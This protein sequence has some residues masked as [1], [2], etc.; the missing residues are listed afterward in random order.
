M[1]KGAS[2]ATG[3]GRLRVGEGGTHR[4]VAP[5][6]HGKARRQEHH[7]DR[8]CKP[9]W[10]A[11]VGE[12]PIGCSA[13]N[14]RNEIAPLTSHSRRVY[15]LRPY[16]LGHCALRQDHTNGKGPG[17][18]GPGPLFFTLIAWLTGSGNSVV[19][20]RHLP[21]PAPRGR[22]S[23]SGT[24]PSPATRFQTPCP[25]PGDRS[26]PASRSVPARRWGRC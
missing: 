13:I 12:F 23:T 21:E 5:E 18:I 22:R 20:P 2:R 14:S 17:P 26:V 6:V 16:H 7:S 25:G 10:T 4:A 9:E 24:T 11:P 15:I 19:S 1:A 8:F 3:V